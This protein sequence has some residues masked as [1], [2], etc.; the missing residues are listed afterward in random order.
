MALGLQLFSNS[1]YGGK[2]AA[3][4]R[5]IRDILLFADFLQLLTVSA[6]HE[7]DRFLL[8]GGQGLQNLS[9]LDQKGAFQFFLFF[10][11][12]NIEWV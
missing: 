1:V 11:D 10:S 3:S 4:Q 2:H 7:I 8:F 5:R 6:E 12:Q 9:H